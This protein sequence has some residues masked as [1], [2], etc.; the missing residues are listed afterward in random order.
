[1]RALAF[2][3][4]HD[5]AHLGPHLNYE[6]LFKLCRAKPHAEHKEGVRIG[7]ALYSRGDVID[8]EIVGWLKKELKSYIDD[9]IVRFSYG[10]WG[11]VRAHDITTLYVDFPKEAPVSNPAFYRKCLIAAVS[12]AHQLCIRWALCKYFTPNRFLS[13]GIAAGDFA[14]LDNYLLP[15]LNA[16]LPGDPVIRLTDYARQCLLIND[17]RALLCAK[18]AEIT[19]FNGETLPIWWVLGLWSTL[20]FDFVPDLLTDKILRGDDRSMAALGGV[21]WSAENGGAEFRAHTE[22]GN[23]IA[24]FFRFPHNSLLGLEIAKTLYYR[25]RFWEAL[26]ILRIVLSLDPTQLN[27]RTLRMVLLRNLALDAGSYAVAE[28]LFKQAHLEAQFI[29]Q[30]CA[31]QSEDF[32]CEFGVLH[33]AQA[34]RTLRDLRLGRGTVAGAGDTKTLQ[35]RVTAG[36]DQAA[37]LFGM[38]MT[39]S[40]TGIRAN[41]LLNS[42]LVLAAVLKSD[43]GIFR[44]PALALDARPEVVRRPAADYQHQ[45]G[46]LRDDLPK[47]EPYALIEKMYKVLTITHDD[48]ISLQ[49][50]RPTTYFCTAVA[51]WDFFPVRTVGLAKRVVQLL[52][53]AADIARSMRGKNICIYSFTRTY[54]EMMPADEFIGHMA[55]GVAMIEAVAGG[56]LAGR[57]D[58]ESIAPKADERASLLMTLNF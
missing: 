11:K 54:G 52:R 42:V 19:L 24:T 37:G 13:I 2:W 18:P 20:Y 35:T 33:L 47:E 15:T 21:L 9:A 50:Y 34:M 16:K 1:L 14:V 5:R 38:G 43:P 7:F 49:A 48:S 6:M 10:R 31:F 22:A 41:Y 27:A 29:Q 36:L 32:Y 44:D 3:L 12:L 4:G 51:W 30:S 8:H 46:Y 55:R 23:A 53:G 56:D 40:P 45:V 57:D 17:I 58:Q 28:G 25:R 26:E 39:V